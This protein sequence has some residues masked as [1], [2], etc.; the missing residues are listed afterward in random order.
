MEVG[1]NPGTVR[2]HPLHI[3]TSCDLT[4][5]YVYSSNDG[6]V[7]DDVP[8]VI[9]HLLEPDILAL[10]VEVL[11]WARLIASGSPYSRNSVRKAGL[12]PSMRMERSALQ[13]R[14]IRLWFGCGSA[15]V[16]L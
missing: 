15:V 12:A 10:E 4:S 1:L 9:A 3:F 2:A 13:R 7:V 16:R 11:L 5:L 6:V 14:I 8:D